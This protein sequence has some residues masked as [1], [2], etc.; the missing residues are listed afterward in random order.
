V[1][2]TATETAGN[3]DGIL[4]PGK[5]FALTERIKNSDSLVPNLTTVKGSLAYDPGTTAQAG[6]PLVTLANSLSNYPNL[7]FGAAGDNITAFTG[8]LSSSAECGVNLNFVLSVTADQGTAQVPFRVP[9]GVAGPSVALQSA[10]VPKPLPDLAATNSGLNIAAAGRVKDIQVR[11]GNLTHTRTADLKIELVSPSGASVVLV[12]G[13]GGSGQNFTNTVFSDSATQSI[14]GAAAPFTGTYRPVQPLSRMLGRGQQGLWQL[15]VTDQTAGNTGTLNAWGMDVRSAVCTATPVASFT[16]TPSPAL[17]GQAIQFDASQSVSPLGTITKYEWDFDNNGVYV[18]G[19]ATPTIGHTY[20]TRGLYPVRL[21]VTDSTARTST[22]TVNVSVTR[23]PIASFTVSPT[24]P[25]SG[26]TTTLDGSASTDPDGFPIARYEWDVDGNGTFR[27]DT[28]SVPTL[29]T[30]WATPGTRSVRLRVTD[31]DGATGVATVNVNV[32]NRP[33]VA[34]LSVPTPAIVGQP[35]TISAAGSYDPDGTIVRYQWDLDNSGTFAT[36]TGTVPQVQQTYA[37]PGTRTVRVRVTDDYGATTVDT[38]T[39][40]I[41]I[42]PVASF[43]ATPNPTSLHRPVAFDASASYDPDGTVVRYE[44]DLD[45]SGAFTTD[46]GATPTVSKV[47]DR[48]GTYTVKLRV[49]DNAGARTT[50]SMDVVAAN[51]LPIAAIAATPSPVAAGAPVT[52]DATGS[53]DPDG[54]IVKYEWDFE[55][56]GAYETTGAVPTVA[57]TYPYPGRFTVGVRVTDNDGGVATATLPL[58]VGPR[59]DG[60]APGW[61]IAPGGTTSGTDPG[62]APGRLR[63][64]L[65]GNALQRLAQ[66]VV[67]GLAVGCRADRA[68]R[69]VLVAELGSSQARRLG[70]GGRRGRAVALG[71]VTI[72]LRAGGERTARLRLTPAGRRALR[73]SRR[74]TVIVRGTVT[75]AGTGATRLSRTFLLRR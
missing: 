36:D 45:G 70:L 73:G 55:G 22:T 26:Q 59:T 23:P 15:R 1:Q 57:H 29:T 2:A 24:S 32:Q 8:T 47:Y 50:Y 53:R 67:R 74:L 68:V 61:G 13:E 14:V 17:P 30:Q 35:A 49:T 51:K 31:I 6:P 9:T 60:G 64:S 5:S 46:T 38:K 16:A 63:V 19:G 71:R 20:A 56:S 11:I 62:S 66:V 18:D 21:R 28:G 10:D 40:T 3:G 39:M 27:V 41:T 69:C 37:A 72:A 4:A 48:A 75:A 7:A 12:D 44:W 43:T 52:L 65:S 34:V 25:L 42:A 54:T 33:P 58:T